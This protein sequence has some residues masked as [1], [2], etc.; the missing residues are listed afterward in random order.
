MVGADRTS[1]RNGEEC[2]MPVNE[3]CDQTSFSSFLVMVSR[4]TSTVR[5]TIVVVNPSNAASSKKQSTA[6]FVQRNV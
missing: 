6:G 4:V 3:Y 2:Y 1:A 5:L